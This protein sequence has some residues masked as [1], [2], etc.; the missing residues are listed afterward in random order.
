M[1]PY[2]ALWIIPGTAHRVIPALQTT[3]CHPN[4]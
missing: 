2:P 1:S 3:S 4:K